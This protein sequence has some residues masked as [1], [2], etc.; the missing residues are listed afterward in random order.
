MHGGT[1]W[2]PPL[3]VL[4]IGLAIGLVLALR[5]AWGKRAA[6]Q[7]QLPVDDVE[8]RDLRVQRDLLLSQLRELDDIAGKRSAEEL[9]RDRWELELEAART[10]RALDRA[11]AKAV[12]DAAAAPAPAPAR[13][14]PAWVGALWGGGVVAF[15]AVLF[16]A[17]QSQTSQRAPGG[18]ITGNDVSVG[19]PAAAMPDPALEAAIARAQA[20][21][22]DV[23][24][25]LDL[26]AEFLYRD[27]L[28]D[29]FQ[30]VQAARKIVPDHARALTYEAVVR[31]AMGLGDMAMSLLD[32]AVQKD[33]QLAEAWVRRGL[34]GFE[35][36]KWQVAVESWEK[37]LE[38]RPD[39]RSAL[40]PVIAEAKLRMQGGAGEPPPAPAA[41]A[42]PPASAPAADGEAYQIVLDLDPALRGK[43]APGT[44]IFVY[45][46]NA[47]V[48]AGPPAAVK[49]LAVSDFPMTVTIGPGDTMMG[50]PLPASA[51][52]EARIDSDGN[53]MTRSPS[54]PT[55]SADDVAPGKSIQLVLRTGG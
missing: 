10:L 40:E 32:Q 53:A 35:Q 49:R 17:L 20:N 45:A 7:R 28:I 19:G 48:K 8:V 46:R 42:A 3:I 41:P 47:G 37:A 24:A 36:G 15:G 14:S 50:M 5:M 1:N 43:V 9:A 22:Q 39:G 6:A 21:P 34:I 55:A 23:D 13:G 38:L 29:V 54:D 30:V 4:G 16:F 44:P 11:E 33:P 26:A 27:R 52:V 31:Q 2:L 51:Y 12:S 18:S 25:Q